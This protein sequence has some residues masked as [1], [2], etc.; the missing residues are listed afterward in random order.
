MP[1]REI[2]DSVNVVATLAELMATIGVPE[3][4]GSGKKTERPIP[5]EGCKGEIGLF[6]V[7]RSQD[8]R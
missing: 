7:I 3:H 4:I 6:R 2:W 1:I 5:Y 8:R